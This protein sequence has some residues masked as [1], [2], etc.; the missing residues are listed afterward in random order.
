[1]TVYGQLRHMLETVAR[2]L[3]PEL[4]ERMVFVGG[5]STALLLT[6]QVTL[7]DVRLTNDV[8]LIIEL[9][10]PGQWI[11]LQEDLYSRGFSV[12]PDDDVVCRMRLERCPIKWNRLIDQTE[13]QL[14]D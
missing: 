3:G 12:S 2:A 9:S 14:K 1:M 11:I 7:G 13:R 5:C 10:G 6:D 4:R 8:D